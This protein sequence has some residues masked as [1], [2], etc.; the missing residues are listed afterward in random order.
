[1][2]NSVTDEGELLIAITHAEAE[3]LKTGAELVVDFNKIGIG[4]KVRIISEP[5]HEEI[6]KRCGLPEKVVQQLVLHDLP[7]T[8]TTKN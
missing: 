6:G 5:N 1:M 2:F 4:A 3:R 8:T 7:T